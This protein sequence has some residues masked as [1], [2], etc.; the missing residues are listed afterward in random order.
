MV[1]RELVT[2]LGFNVDKGKLD[3]YNASVNQIKKGMDNATNAGVGAGEKINSSFSGLMTTANL[4]RGAMVGIGLAIANSMA[5][6]IGN[7]TSTSDEMLNLSSRIGLVTSSNDERLAIEEKLFD[8][9]QR[10]RQN[11]SATGDLYYKVALSAKELGSTQEDA[12]NITETVSK[13]LV[14]GGASAQ[15]ASATILQLSQALGSGFLQGDELRSLREN[16]PVLMQG[17]SEYFGKTVGQLKEM[18][19]KGE[20]ASADVAKAII[21]SR[22]KIDENFEK[23]P[24]TVEQSFTVVS[25]SFKKFMGDLEKETGFFKALA[26]GI[27]AGVNGIQNGFRFLSKIFG[28]SANLIKAITISISALGLA[29]VATNFTKIISGI[30][31][32]AV[33]M[34]G[35]AVANALATWEF[36]L[37]AAV[38]AVIILAIQD[39][40]TWINGGDSLLGRWLG[41]W[42]EFKTKSAT[43]FQPITD[44]WNRLYP[45]LLNAWDTI[46]PKIMELGNVISVFLGQAFNFVG[47]VIMWLV[48]QFVELMTTGGYVAGAIVALFKGMANVIINII[49]LIVNIFTGNWSGAIANVK[50]LFTSL[51]NMVVGVLTNIGKAIG[52][53][54]LNKL[55]QAKNAVM[56]FLGWS[57]TQTSNA[58]NDNRNKFNQSI[59]VNQNFN[60]TTGAESAGYMQK[61]AEDS[62][63]LLG[64]NLKWGY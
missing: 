29:L 36:V 16:A 35:F 42:E 12:L 11:L 45:V 44:A 58:I 60:G 40:Y 52:T 13:S 49:G 18:G 21:F 4:V 10:T 48:N 31:A 57:N 38:I 55:S 39:L 56:D 43:F 3:Q 25:N 63:T 28:G 8:M 2:K 24:L 5:T 33:A 41:S 22:K 30:K 59:Y 32:M 1:I 9:S 46:K 6:A 54:I 14:V 62:S 61:S 47:S 34:R 64:N 7:I 53:Y 20:L 19:A 27:V 51:Y 50:G 26:K 17:I 15:Q 37:I 23:M